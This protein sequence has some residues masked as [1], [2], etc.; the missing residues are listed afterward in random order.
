MYD[1]DTAEDLIIQRFK[2]ECTA[3]DISVSPD[4]VA[5]VTRSKIHSDD[6]IDNL[7][8]TPEIELLARA[9]FEWMCDNRKKACVFCER[10]LFQMVVKDLKDIDVSIEW[11]VSQIMPYVQWKQVVIEILIKLPSANEPCGQWVTNSRNIV[12]ETL[13]SHNISMRD[14]TTMNDNVLRYHKDIDYKAHEP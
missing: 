5:I 4:K 3:C 1:K 6:S 11:D 8:K 7:W 2:E 9:S 12:H 10:A 14:G 13:V